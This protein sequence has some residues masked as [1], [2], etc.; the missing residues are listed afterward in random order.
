MNI[1]AERVPKGTE[2]MTKHIQHQRQKEIIEIILMG[3]NI[4][5]TVKTMVFEGF[6]GC[7][8]DTKHDIKFVPKLITNRCQNDAPK[9]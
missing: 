2:S 8:R 1:Y 4:Q 9:K 7:V 5:G 3:K 6:T